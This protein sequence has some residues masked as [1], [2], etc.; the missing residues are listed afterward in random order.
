MSVV[1]VLRGGLAAWMVP[2]TLCA[3]SPVLDWRE[4]RP[5][6]SGAQLL[7]PCKPSNEV[8]TVELAGARVRMH[9]AACSADGATWALAYADIGDPAL[10]ARA[11]GSLRA[12][13]AANLAASAAVTGP[14][15]V[16][17]MT[18]NAQAERLRA[19]GRMPGGD[20]VQVESG[21]FVRGTQVYQATVMGKAPAPEA[22]GIFFDSLKLPS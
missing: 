7:F 18:P 1:R 6:A 3:C 8:R 15:K 20:A 12:A 5:D 10:V 11:L 16:P 21:F 14:M 4:V 22:V 17:G 2:F 13:S 19:A 9:M